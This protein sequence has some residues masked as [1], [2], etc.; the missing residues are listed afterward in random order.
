MNENILHSLAE[1]LAQKVNKALNI[2]V[3]NEKQEQVF[4]EMVILLLLELLV[5]KFGI[6]LEVNN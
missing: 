1:E 5:N 3:L 6:N 4:F 2:P